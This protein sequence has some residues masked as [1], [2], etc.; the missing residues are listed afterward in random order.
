MCTLSVCALF[1]SLLL[2][3]PALR[4]IYVFQ[5]VV[6]SAIG[7]SAFPRGAHCNRRF[8]SCALLDVLC[9]SS[10]IVVVACSSLQQSPADTSQFCLA[11][12]IDLQ[13]SP[14]GTSQ[15]CMLVIASLD[16]HIPSIVITSGCPLI[17]L[18]HIM[19]APAILIAF[20]LPIILQAYIH[21]IWSLPAM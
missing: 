19:A 13:R 2:L 11:S 9:A 21:T 3:L 14:V 6:P 12:L 17:D 20:L 4:V 18:I 10:R 1:F 5:I 7:V 16:Q 15:F 8:S